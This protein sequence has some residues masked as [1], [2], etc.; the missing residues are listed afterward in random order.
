MIRNMI[1]QIPCHRRS[2]RS[3]LKLQK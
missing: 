3:F 2:D 1:L